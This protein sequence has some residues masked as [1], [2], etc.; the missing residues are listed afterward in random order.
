MPYI[1]PNEVTS[2]KDSWHLINVVHDEGEGNIAVA[3]G[4][5]DGEKVIAIRWNGSNEPNKGLGN[6]QSTGYATWFILPK[7]FGIAIINEILKSKN[8]EEKLGI[9]I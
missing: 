1:L 2:P 3:Y 6:P 8:I 5:W 7:S 4:E 9:K